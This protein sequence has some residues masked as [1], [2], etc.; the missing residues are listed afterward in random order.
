MN[1]VPGY[2]QGTYQWTDWSQGAQQNL[3][4]DQWYRNP[5]WGGHVVWNPNAGWQDYGT[6]EHGYESGQT[7]WTPQMGGD[8]QQYFPDR[9]VVQD[10]PGYGQSPL[11][12]NW[13]DMIS[14][15]QQWFQGNRQQPDY[16]YGQQNSNMK[17]QTSQ[18]WMYGG[19]GSGQPSGSPTNP[20]IVRAQGENMGQGGN[21]SG[22]YQGAGGFQYPSQWQTASD[23]MSNFALG[24]PTQIPWQWQ[25]GSDIASQMAQTGMPTSYE[26]AYQ[27]AKGIAE[28]DTL[29][30]IKAAAEQVG[31]S[32]MRWSTPMG[33]TAQDIAGRNMA[34][35][36][37]GFTQQELG[38][39]EA[40][41]NRQLSGISALQGFGQG[42]AGLTE[43]AKDRGLS[44]AGGL[45]GLGQQYL[46][47]P[48]DWAAQTYQMGA[49]MQDQ[50]QSALDRYREEYMR[51]SP[52][53]NPWITGAMNYFGM[54]SQM[55]YSQYTAS[56]LSQITG[57]A[58]T[59]GAL[60]LGL[61]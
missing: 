6:V 57:A 27:K 46:N 55:G 4:Q 20:E 56:P 17:E 29:D 16:Q 45:T 21:M 43:S 7:N 24:A 51:M 25:Q 41:R 15:W 30:A 52:E 36:G 54:P 11:P 38:A 48:Q 10:Q 31:L 61:C 60:G 1:Q 40:A 28:T 32:G 59:A 22:G 12:S 5:S 18:G 35:L 13:G 14:Q 53:N 37:L 50:A 23:V 33:R 8:W 39:Q 2:G 58:G 44:A 9:P 26:L 34:Q 19:Q 47:A 49:G 3:G 42:T